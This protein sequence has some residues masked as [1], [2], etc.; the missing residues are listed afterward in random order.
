MAL[1]MEKGDPDIMKRP[2]RP[3][4]EPVINWEMQIGTGVQAVVMTVAVL[5]C[6]FLGLRMY[7]NQVEHAQTMAFGTLCMSELLRAYTARSEH[8]GVFSIGPFSNRW[9]NW[10]VG[11]S[12]ALVLV[13][14]YVPFLQPFFDTTPLSVSDW[15]VMIPFILMASAAAE[16]TKVYIRKR[17]AKMTMPVAARPEWNV[18]P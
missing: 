17:S 12:A 9:M 16:L 8:Y 3:T 11:G 1:G 4:K 5:V 10:A 6:Y 15:L 7:P 14:I 13:T 18:S 2:P